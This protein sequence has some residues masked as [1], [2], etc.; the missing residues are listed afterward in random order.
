MVQNLTVNTID[1]EKVIYKISYTLVELISLFVEKEILN[2]K[3][4]VEKTKKKKKNV[5]VNS[6]KIGKQRKFFSICSEW[7]LLL[8]STPKKVLDKK[9]TESLMRI[10]KKKKSK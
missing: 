4:I 5:F 9:A 10:S 2:V 7:D 1:I 3:R 6:L 8:I